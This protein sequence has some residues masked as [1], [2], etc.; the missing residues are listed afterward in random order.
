MIIR[1]IKFEEKNKLNY[2]DGGWQRT[3]DKEWWI[4]GYH[5]TTIEEEQVNEN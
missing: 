5:E 4:S 3:T 2:V 1:A